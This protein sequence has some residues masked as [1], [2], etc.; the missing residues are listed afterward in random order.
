MNARDALP[1]PQ[2]DRWTL[3][4]LSLLLLPL[5]TM[6]HELGGHALTCVALGQH[7]T[8]LGAFYIECPSAVGTAG[9]LVAMAGTSMDVLVFVLGFFAWRHARRPLLRLALWIVF[10]VKGMVAAGYWLFSGVTGF[11]DWGP[12]AGGGIGPLPDPWLWRIGFTVVGL[13]AYIAVVRLAMRTLDEMLGGGADATRTR[14]QV[15]MTVYI[16]GGASALLVSLMNPHGFVIVLMSAVAA[17]FGG[18]AGLFNVAFHAEQSG[19]AA[20]FCVGRHWGLLAIGAIVLLA[21]AAVL[22]PTVYLR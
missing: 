6:A 21:Y 3:I 2:V 7:P 17:T 16:V 22:G 11:G 8:E 12:G 4:G 1:M 13:I 9:R 15:A 5:L 18:T 20:D 14:R 10:T 19:P